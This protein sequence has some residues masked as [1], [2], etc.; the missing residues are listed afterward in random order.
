MDRDGG[1]HRDRKATDD[2]D[3]VVR[4]G[5]PVLRVPSSLFFAFG[6]TSLK[7]EGKTMLEIVA[8][9]VGNKMTSGLSA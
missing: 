7:P 8:D 3:V 4:E 5:R 6:E 9:T 2:T 1:G